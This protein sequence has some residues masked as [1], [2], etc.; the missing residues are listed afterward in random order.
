MLN[1]KYVLQR[2][3]MVCGLWSEEIHPSASKRWEVVGLG[4]D[5]EISFRVSTIFDQFLYLK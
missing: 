4:L 3:F 1:R 5:L 2:L